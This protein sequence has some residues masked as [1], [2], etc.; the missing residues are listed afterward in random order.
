MCKTLRCGSAGLERGNHEEFALKKW[1]HDRP[2]IWIV[3]L[4]AVMTTGS[5]IMMTI[6]QMNKP[7]VVKEH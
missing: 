3:L 7:E 4:L 1:L 2:W 5:T 6:A